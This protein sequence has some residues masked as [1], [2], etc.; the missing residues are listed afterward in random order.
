[1]RILRGKWR[2]RSIAFPGTP[3]TRPLSE[4]AREGL[5][6]SLEAR[7]SIPQK[8]V[9]DLFAG[10]GSIGLE[11]LSRGA[12]RCTFVEKDPQ[13][14]AHLRR[15]AQAWGISQSIQILQMDAL[16]F[17]KGPVKPADFIY[18]G[19]P[20]RYWQRKTVLS[21]LRDRGW[22]NPGGY[23]ILEHPLY[24]SYS[25]WGGFVHSARY[26]SGCLSFFSW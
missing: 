6:N 23:C 7:T 5:F 8:T 17:L 3:S 1:M 9:I 21:I 12:I 10:S 24:E 20:Y 14:A 22:L 4:R 16:L 13:A 15:L 2:G 26:L 19:A 18:I 25:E 11:F